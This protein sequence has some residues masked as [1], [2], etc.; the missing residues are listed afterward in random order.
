[1][2]VPAGTFKAL[3]ITHSR[4]VWEEY[5]Y[6]PEVKFWVKYADRTYSEELVSFHPAPEPPKE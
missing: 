6:A 3:H 2:T 5:W 1:V 4:W